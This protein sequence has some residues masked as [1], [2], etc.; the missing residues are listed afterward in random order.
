[1]DLGEVL[2]GVCWL[3]ERIGWFWLVLQP[4]GF[5]RGVRAR[6]GK[7]KWPTQRYGSSDPPGRA[8]V[9][10]RIKRGS[11][12]SNSPM[13][14]EAPQGNLRDALVLPGCKSGFRAIFRPD[15]N[16]EDFSIGHPADFE[17]LPTKISGRSPAP[18]TA[19]RPGSTIA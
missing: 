11:W 2:G 4:V 9:P 10:T 18:K 12:G 5:N 3:F 6:P 7:A 14:A 8:V 13:E 16:R 1:V 19:F 15:S 17:A